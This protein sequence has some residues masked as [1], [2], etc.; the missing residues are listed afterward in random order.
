MPES[1]TRVEDGKTFPIDLDV[2]LAAENGACECLE[3]RADDG[4]YEDWESKMRS[5]RW[6]DGKMLSGCQQI[7][8]QYDGGRAF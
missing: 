5:L 4:A 7:F 8:I 2:F 6:T 3:I 1:E